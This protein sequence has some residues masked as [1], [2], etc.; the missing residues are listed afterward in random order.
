MIDLKCLIAFFS[1]T[2]ASSF[3]QN[4]I[5]T[6]DLS[7]NWQLTNDARKFTVKDLDIP[8]SVH[9]ALLR[10]SLIQKPLYGFNDVDLRWIPK[11]NRWV[12]TRT[13]NINDTLFQMI[14]SKQLLANLEFFS[15]DTIA[16]VYLNGQFILFAS[17]Q[18]LKYDVENVNGRLKQGENELVIKF[19]SPIEYAK[20]QSDSYPY[21]VP[22]ECPPSVQNGECH[23]NKI[24]KQQC[25]FSW[26][27]GPA[28]APIGLNDKIILKLIE[29]FNMDF[30]VDIYPKYF[31]GT[32]IFQIDI[33][34]WLIDIDVY[35]IQNFLKMNQLNSSDLKIRIPKLNYENQTK[36]TLDPKKTIRN[37]LFEIS[38]ERQEASLQNDFLWFPSGYGQQHLFEL[39]VECIAGANSVTKST[40]IGFRVA[41]LIDEPIDSENLEKGNV[42]LFRINKIDTFLKGSN[43]IPADSFQENISNEYLEWLLLS[44]KEANMNVLR[45]WGGGIYEREYFY[46]LAD[47]LGIL[48]WQDFMFACSMYPTNPDFLTNVA[49]EIYYQVERLKHHPSILLWGGNNENEVALAHDWY[50]TRP[51]YE[52]YAEDYRAL[53]IRLIKNTVSEIDP[54]QSTPYLSSSPTNGKK[55]E[56]DNWI[57][58]NPYDLRYGDIHFYNY[59]MD[60]WE[61]KNYPIS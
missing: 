40:I 50:Q 14:S 42:F 4:S 57:S 23:V 33:D 17:N 32:D 12:F 15:I 39:Q 24:R 47:R 20:N 9:T 30:S 44:V 29:N 34:E 19:K 43:W 48:I 13:F 37:V 35:V 41:E 31:I 26:D 60:T 38:A 16:N 22:V 25:S 2:F 36:I 11:D 51:N 54:Y 61:P 1:L 55:S 46:D 45:V 53:Y 3:A 56:K 7:Q 18:F 6:I 52:T 10:D 59:L 58:E 49:D 28:F 8:F 27:W 5:W 21:R